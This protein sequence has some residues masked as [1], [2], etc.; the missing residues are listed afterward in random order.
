MIRQTLLL[1][2]VVLLTH[3]FILAF[4]IFGLITTLIGGALKWQWIKNPWFRLSHLICIW[5]VVMQAWAGVVCPLTTLEMWFRS[6]AGQQV[7][8]G[9]FI[10]HWLSRRLYYNFPA[11]V[12]TFAYT[13]FGALVLVSWLWV[14]PRSIKSHV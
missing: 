7:Y 14:R 13:T 12:F 11:W 2:D 1:A 3:A 4:V 9:S 5:I 10:S 8:S 6:Q